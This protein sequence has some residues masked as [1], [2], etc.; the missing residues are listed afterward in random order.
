MPYGNFQKRVVPRARPM[1]AQGFRANT[2]TLPAPIGGWNARDSLAAMAPIDAVTMQDWWPMTS[3]VM[4]RKGYTQYSTGLSGQCQTVMAYNSPTT[5]KLWGAC[6]SGNIYDVTAGG[7][8]GAAAVTGLSSGWFQF[9]NAGTGSVYALLAVN[10]ADKLQGY[11]GSWYKDGDGSHDITGVDTSTCIHINLF[12]TRVFLVQKGTLKAWYLPVNAI[13]GA[14]NSL[15]FSGIARKGGYLMAMG[16]WTL[17]AGFGAD[18]YAVFIT[19]QGE[20]IVYAGTDPSSSA[21]WALIGVWQLGSPIGRRCFLKWAGDMLLISYDGVVPLAEGL[22][23]TRLDPRV[24]L[25]DKIKN[26]MSTATQTYGGFQGWQLSYYAK[27]NM[28]LLNVPITTGASQQQYVMNTITKAWGNFTG[29]AANCLEIYLDDLYFGGNGYVGKAWN[30][31]S[32]NG[33]QLSGNCLQAFSQLTTAVE[34]ANVAGGGAQ[35]KRFTMM[36]PVLLSNGTPTISGSINVDFD[37]NVSNAALSFTP[38]TYATWDNAVWDTG[39]WGGGLS[40]QKSW[41]GASSIGYWCAPQLNIKSSGIETHWVSTDL[42][43]E[44]GGVI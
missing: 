42:V 32:D 5:N 39:T 18:D 33:N 7:A 44:K 31:F 3:D 8:V 19:S 16:T 10:G 14:A 11:T 6:S 15:D 23:S 22:Q 2:A 40:V 25:S 12:K 20:V 36:R 21:T 35:Q 27:G 9:V 28:L 4:F 30:T 38:T 26:A 41:Q 24:N 13:S 34:A 1:P 29:Y 17:D 43:Y 37:T